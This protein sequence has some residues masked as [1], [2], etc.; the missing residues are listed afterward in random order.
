LKES[1]KIIIIGPPGTGKTTIKRVFFDLANP[2][3]LLESSLEPTRGVNSSIYSFFDSYL[4]VFDLAGQENKNWFTTDKDIFENSSVILCVF[5]IRNSLKL[6]MDF[7]LKI[8]KI[9]E[10][11][12]LYEAL[13]IVLIHKIDLIKP[14]YLSSKVQTIKDLLRIKIPQSQDIRLY[15]TSI[16]KEYFFKTYYVIL[17]VL[18]LLFRKELIPISQ[19]EFLRLKTDLTI[20]LKLE[21]NVKYSLEMLR[22]KFG[23]DFDQTTLHLERLKNLDLI[24]V[25][26]TKP[27]SF[28]LTERAKFLRASIEKERKIIDESRIN[29]GIELFYTFLN[30]QK[31][32]INSIKSLKVKN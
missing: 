19:S 26:E 32:R 2:I 1:K 29:K 11:L 4:G 28:K 10:K 5:D 22:T 13:I 18:N 24:E 17:E 6:I 21:R 14:S 3:N 25:F 15:Q 27:F 12:R 30:L 20:I 23:L 7:L 16:A 8:I 31:K 9:K